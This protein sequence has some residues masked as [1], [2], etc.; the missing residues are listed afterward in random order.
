MAD[1][2]VFHESV[3]PLQGQVGPSPHGLLVQAAKPEHLADKMEVL[4]SLSMP[5]DAQAALEAKVEKGETVSP[6]ELK[7]SYAP[8]QGDVDALVNWLKTQSFTGIHVSNDGAGVYAQAQVSQIE[9]SLEVQMVRVTKDGLTYTAAQN[10]PSLPADVGAPVNA[11]VGLQP[12]R[13]A[14]KHS[15]LRP[16]RG[17][18]RVGL[19]LTDGTGP[20]TNV[21]NAPPY[22][23][24]EILKAYGADKL[25][26][27]GAGQT[28]GILIDTVPADSDVQAFWQ[29]NGVKTSA[30]R[31]VKVNVTGAHLP[32]PSGEETLDV[33]WSSSIAP[34]A[35]VRVYATGSLSFVD[36]DKGLDQILTDASSDKTMRQ[37]SISLGLGET[38]FGGAGGEV[39]T[40]H[41]KFLKLAAIGVNVFV[42]TGD[43]GSNPDQTGH[44]SDGPLQA[45]YESSDPCV[46]AVG[47]TSLQLNAS[48]AVASETGWSSGGGGKSRYFPRPAWQHDTGVPHG[49]TRVVPDVSLTADPDYG[50][51]LILQGKVVQI[52]GTS[53]SAPVWAGFCALLNEAR[54]SAGKPS[55]AFLNPLIYP[56]AKTTCFRD[57][58]DGSNGAYEAGPGF[59]LVTG[60]GVP[61]VAALIAAL[62]K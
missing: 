28:I 47:G 21:E 34:A 36:L 19:G 57:I 44:G 15:V 43:A 20:T 2:K 59:D 14:H 24:A 29:K 60:L 61:N 4:F 30:T 10:A 9:R 40:Q 35:T 6:D 13:R 51:C 25:T 26:V 62:T 48:G 7:R 41:Q 22:L 17:A 58:T 33:E 54:V 37:V 56:L 45:E 12:F 32:A 18:N 23:V 49:K 46:V 8:K 3:V 31:V 5:K 50:A 42:S 11:I 27:T 55:L 16:P 53:W 1:R 52:G 38:Y 39:A